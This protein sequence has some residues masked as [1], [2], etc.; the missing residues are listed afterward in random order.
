MRNYKTKLLI[1]CCIMLLLLSF[2]LL[3]QKQ[4]STLAQITL[5]NFVSN[6]QVKE[7]F[8]Q[9]NFKVGN[10]MNGLYAPDIEC[11]ES[12]YTK[13]L[14]ELVKEKPVLICVYKVECNTCKKNEL[15]ELQEVF[16]N[17]PGSVYILGSYLIRRQI[18]VYANEQQINISVLGISPDS[19]DWKAETYNQPYFFILHPD[20][21]IS[22]VYFPSKEYSELNKQYLEG[23]KRLFFDQKI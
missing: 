9:T 3:N 20:M 14:S 8:Y 10:D 5:S 19:F 23:V 6:L 4:K 11:L 16:Q 17:I 2:Y 18:Y 12:Y 7:D 21:K 22:H 13:K 15:N 1:A